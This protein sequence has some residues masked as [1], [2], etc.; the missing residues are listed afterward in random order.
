MKKLILFL[1]ISILSGSIY[2]QK[3]ALIIVDIQNDYFKGG[4]M[5]LVGSDEA[6]DNAQAIIKKFREA[7]MPVIFIQHINNYKGA[8]FFL[9]DTYGNKI[10]DKVK[11]M[12]GEEIIV[13]HLPNSFMNTDLLNCLKKSNIEDV[14][15]VGMMTHMCIDATTRAAKD[16]G[17]NCTL[18]GDACATRDISHEGLTVPA[19]YVQAAYLAA[20]NGAYA[21]VIST[22]SFLEQMN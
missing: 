11:P 18:I 10:N 12:N 17:Y 19:K 8:T 7:G 14:V 22:K 6:A 1:F 21:N 13:K 3:K 5:E 2:A 9:P 20:L 16:L 4:A 15:I